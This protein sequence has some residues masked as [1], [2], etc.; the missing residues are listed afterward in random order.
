MATQQK[1]EAGKERT[2]AAKKKVVKVDAFGKVYV[3]STF[4]NIIISITNE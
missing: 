4:N 1:G 2:K 3:N